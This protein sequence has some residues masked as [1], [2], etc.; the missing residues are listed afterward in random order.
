MERE[1]HC[2]AYGCKT[3]CPPA[4]F[5]CKPH[6]AMVPSIYKMAIKNTYTPGQETGKV[7]PSKKWFEWTLLA[8]RAV[9]ERE[10][11]AKAL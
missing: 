3:P 5:M 9:K 6:W 7:R 10:E 1:H 11:E 4:M 2:H 8:L